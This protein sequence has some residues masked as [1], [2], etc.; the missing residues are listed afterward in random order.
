MLSGLGALFAS[1]AYC[2]VWPIIKTLVNGGCAPTEKVIVTGKQNASCTVQLR[3]MWTIKHIL[4]S[5]MHWDVFVSIN[6]HVLVLLFIRSP[7]IFFFCAHSPTSQRMPTT[8]L[9]MDATRKILLCQ[10]RFQSSLIFLL[11]KGKPSTAT[12]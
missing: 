10:T 12:N 9:K 6:S 3:D 11:I 2:F 1:F 5:L 8:E 7:S 4:N